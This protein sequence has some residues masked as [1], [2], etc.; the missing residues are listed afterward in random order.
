M[1]KTTI[2]HKIFLIGFGILLTLFILEAGLRLGGFIFKWNQDSDNRKALSRN[3]G[4][5]RILCIGESTTALGG[6]NSYPF[7]LEEILNHKGL[8]QKFKIINKGMVAKISTDIVEQLEENLNIYKPDLVVSMVG[9]NDSLI[10]REKTWT[11]TLDFWLARFRI[12][13]FFKFLGMHINHRIKERNQDVLIKNERMKMASSEGYSFSFGSEAGGDPPEENR[14]SKEVVAKILQLELLS[15][16]LEKYL[17]KTEK[18]Q[19][20]Q[21]V[22]RQLSQTKMK[23]QWL[24]VY[25]GRYYR[26]RENYIEA[27]NY[28][29][30]AA[31]QDPQSY[32]AYL[33]L[34]RVY[35]DQKDYIKAI[36]LFKKAAEIFP[37]G[38]LSLIEMGRCY[39]EL[40]QT[41][42]TFELYET[43]FRRHPDDFWIYPEIGKWFKA[44]EFFPQAQEV[45]ELAIHIDPH[46]YSLYDQ[47]SEI[48][49]VQGKPREAES[50]YNQGRLKEAGVY[51]YLPSTIDNYNRIT[52]IVFSRE[53]KLICM[54]YPLRSVEPLKNILKSRKKI[55]FVENKSN[56]QGALK[57]AEYSNYFSDTFGGDFGHCTRMGNHLIAE[58][59]SNV[60]FKE[61]LRKY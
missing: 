52:D 25:L 11:V 32:S 3:H 2:K 37:A 13:N 29:K 42:K 4:D 47:L 26:M 59:L 24:L 54:Q 58:N 10:L 5:F 6:E 55:I 60:I 17:Q 1:S 8:K 51:K 49:S 44:H 16:H 7:Q 61:I 28:L 23:I 18:T 48:Y 56:F 34:G 21:K 39:N 36:A 22:Q 27:Q 20:Y 15:K 12:Y 41:L 57:Q 40:G 50:F 31:A 33:E 35:K 30:I 53:I 38:N 46:D 45:F 9:I 19:A 14:N 43:V